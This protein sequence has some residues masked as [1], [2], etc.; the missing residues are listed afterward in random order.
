MFH[1]FSYLKAFL[2]QTR[3][4]SCVKS[5]RQGGS[6]GGGEGVAL[7]WSWL[8][9]GELVGRQGGTPVLGCDWGTPLPSFPEKDLGSETRDK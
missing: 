2:P 6:E 3:K 8:G 7:P 4:S 9:E 5:E 1:R